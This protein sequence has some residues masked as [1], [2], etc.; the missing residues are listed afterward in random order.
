[1]R[2]HAR[3]DRP[4]HYRSLEDGIPQGRPFSILVSHDVPFDLGQGK[5]RHAP[6]EEWDVLLSLA[7]SPMRNIGGLHCI[8]TVSSQ[9]EERLGAP[10]HMCR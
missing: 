5:A 4:V 6:G 1:V 7:D 10:N 3:E 9:P 2:L 8:L